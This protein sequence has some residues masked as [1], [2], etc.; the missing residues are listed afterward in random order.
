[1]I[2]GGDAADEI[3]V[4]RGGRLEDL[5]GLTAGTLYYVSST[6]GAITSTAPTSPRRVAMADST[7]SIVICAEIPEP[8][9]GYIPLD[10]T[11]AR[12]LAA[13]ATQNAAANGGILASDTTP[14]LQ[15]VNGA[16]DQ[17]LRINWAAGNSDV[18]TW[19]FSYPPDLDD[20]QA[21]EVHLLAAMAG[22]TN[23]TTIAVAYFEGVGDTD[24]GGATAAVTGTAVAEY[25]R[26]IAASDIGA[27]PNFAAVSLTPGT[28]GTDAMFLYH[29]WIEY[30]KKLQAT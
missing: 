30:T 21:L 8:V 27:H 3:T 26:T 24:A 14:I 19:S 2:T 12:E 25:S 11:V 20:T 23:G 1:V 7:T 18:I 16:T 29:A 5:T 10:L 6:A 15:R 4:R 17:A 13:G 22:T 28:H 9:K